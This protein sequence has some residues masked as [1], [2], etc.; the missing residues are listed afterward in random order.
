MRVDGRLVLIDW[1]T[2]ALAA[3]ERDLALVVG[4]PADVDRYQEAAGRAIDPAVI[5]LYRLR[6]YLDDLSSAVGMFRSPHHDTPDTRQ[7]RQSLAPLL[8]QF[9]R[10]LDLLG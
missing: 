4:G 6:W 8:E 7:W 9:P 10:W 1:D 3:P 5:T 2:V